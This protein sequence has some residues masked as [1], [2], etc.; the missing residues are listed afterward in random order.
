MDRA[1]TL[2]CLHVSF[3]SFAVCLSTDIALCMH[4]LPPVGAVDGF[5]SGWQHCWLL[6]AAM[7]HCLLRRHPLG[8]AYN[9][10]IIITGNATCLLHAINALAAIW[11]GMNVDLVQRSSL[12][13]LLTLI[14][15]DSTCMF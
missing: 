6:L 3:G 12:R 1:C 15:D 10:A 9:Q 7:A 4:T 11:S 5:C 14:V 8:D 2:C 13:E